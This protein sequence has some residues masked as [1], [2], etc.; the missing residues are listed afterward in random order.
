MKTNLK[1]V[2]LPDDLQ[3]LLYL[4]REE[5]KGR[6]L[7]HALDQAGLGDCDYQPHLDSLI[8]QFAGL[9]SNDEIFEAYEKIMEKRSQ[10]IRDDDESITQQALKV[11]RKL[12]TQ[13]ELY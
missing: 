6:K 10:K 5:L 11:Y 8:L 9:E 13:K 12:M 2:K 1:L 3:V 4:I 7:F